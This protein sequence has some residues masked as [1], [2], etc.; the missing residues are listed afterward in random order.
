MRFDGTVGFPG[1]FIDEGESLE[2][3]LKRELL[4]ELGATAGSVVLTEDDRVVS[5]LCPDK[6]LCLHFYC[7]KIDPDVLHTIE[8]EVLDIP[9]YGLEASSK[10]AS[11][12]YPLP[13]KSFV[14]CWV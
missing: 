14:K 5:H 10:L 11:L 12:S 13:G 8:R 9:Q 6:P 1:G 4:E 3:G 7:K 2:N